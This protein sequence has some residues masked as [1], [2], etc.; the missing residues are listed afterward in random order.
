MDF[1]EVSLL[2]W[3]NYPLPKFYLYTYPPKISALNR[4]A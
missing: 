1:E 4:M 3:F 2:D